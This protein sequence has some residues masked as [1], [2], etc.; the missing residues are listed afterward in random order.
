MT[1]FISEAAQGYPGKLRPFSCSF[2]SLRREH[3]DPSVKTILFQDTVF[4]KSTG[5]TITRMLTITASDLYGLPT[6]P[7]D[8]IL[9]GLL[10]L[11]RI[12]N[13]ATPTVTFTPC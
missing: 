3:L 13:F 8:E 7:D 9:I 2:E 6:A 12:Q 5:K 10:Q 4:D 11:S 1:V